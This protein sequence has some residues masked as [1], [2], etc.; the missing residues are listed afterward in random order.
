MVFIVLSTASVVGVLALM[1]IH[2]RLYG[3]P[4]YAGACLALW[5]L[6]VGVGGGLLLLNVYPTVWV[7]DKGIQIWFLFRRIFIPWHAVLGVQKASPA[8]VGDLVVARKI[9]PFH[10]LYSWIYGTRSEP[11][12]LIGR[13]IANRQELLHKIR[14][15]A[16]GV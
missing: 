10:R 2:Q 7:G 9:T 15:N 11:G 13:G 12:F 8:F 5:T 3:E 1:I 16:T 6:F 14:H 4:F